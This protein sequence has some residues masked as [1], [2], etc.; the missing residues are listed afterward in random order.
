MAITYDITQQELKN[1]N[2]RPL[3]AGDDYEHL[4]TVTGKGSLVGAK[5][6]LTVKENATDDDTA[7]KLQLDSS[8]ADQIEITDGAAGEFMV[9][10]RSAE[11]GV[12]GHTTDLI[13]GTWVY[14]IQIKT[15]AGI[16]TS[17]DGVIEFAPNITKAST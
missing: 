11:N 5:I 7:A 4:F 3:H 13:A 16:T 15:A 17:I 14:D 6:W 9:K 1:A 8:D 2:K 12:S 10:F